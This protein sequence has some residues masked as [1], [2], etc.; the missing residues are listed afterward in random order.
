MRVVFTAYLV[1]TIGVLA[2]FW[3][4]GLAHY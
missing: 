2:Y 1:F 4:I 3:V